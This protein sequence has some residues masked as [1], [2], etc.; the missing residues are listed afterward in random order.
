MLQWQQR[1]PEG[2]AWAAWKAACEANERLRDAAPHFRAS[3]NRDGTFRIDDVPAGDYTLS[4]RFGRDGKLS[5][6]R[7]SVPSPEKNNTD[8]PLDLGVLVLQ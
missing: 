6:H 4:V 2:K 5:G 7:F 1:T 8:Q 3:V